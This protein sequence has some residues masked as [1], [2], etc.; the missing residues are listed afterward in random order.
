[1]GRGKKKTFGSVLL[2]FKNHC[3]ALCLSECLC[4]VQL[5]CSISLHQDASST[6]FSGNAAYVMGIIRKPKGYT[7][8]SGQDRNKWTENS[9]YLE[10]EIKML[11]GC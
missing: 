10:E 5:S 1:M 2:P 4:F 6:S 11:I 3:A 7:A 9:H 8:L